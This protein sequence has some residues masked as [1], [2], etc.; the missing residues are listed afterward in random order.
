MSSLFLEIFSEEI[1]ALLQN[2]AAEDLA[3]SVISLFVE[4]CGKFTLNKKEVFVTPRRMG[5]YLEGLP[6]SIAPKKEIIRGPRLNAPDAAIQGFL[7]KYNL[8]DKNELSSEGDFYVY[9]QVTEAI[10]MPALAKELIEKALK[11]YVWPQ[12]MRW[13]NNKE[14]WVRPIHSISCLWGNQVVPVTFAGVTASNFTF[15]HRFMAPAKIIFNSYNPKFKLN[16]D[17]KSQLKDAFV[18]LDPAERR[19][20]ILKQIED[21]TKDLGLSWRVDASLL[22]E[23]AGLV[24]YPVVYL[25]RIRAEFMDLP[26]ELLVTVLRNHQRYIML[27]D[28][29]G[30]LTSYFVIVSN[31]KA[32]NDGKK[33]IA[34]N[35]KV[36]EARLYDAKFFLDNDRKTTL[37]SKVEKLKILVYHAQIGTVYD[38]VMRVQQLSTLIAKQLGLNESLISRAAYLAKADLTTGIVGEF[39]ELQGVMGYYYA[40]HDGEEK[41]VAKA[42]AEHYKPQGLSDSLPNTEIGAALALADKLCALNS[43]FAQGIRPTGSKDPYALRRAAIG[44]LRILEKF[45][46]Q[47]SFSQLQISQDVISFILTRLDSLR[48]EGTLKENWQINLV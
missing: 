27:E 4:S 11:N 47:L 22:N 15:G 37:E 34:G 9:R 26:P 1:P 42:I 40:L 12:S 10:K 35:T 41:E 25:G 28:K 13:G 21:K 30:N 8:K 18:I 39:P 36:L 46:W 33:I 17:Y 6:D 5:F 45:N 43:F 32:E 19:Q 7:R 44:V 16:E 2:K 20:S 48:I 38:H 24:E 23:I 14:R 3:S 29:H 31:I